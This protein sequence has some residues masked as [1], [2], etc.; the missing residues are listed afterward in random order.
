[1]QQGSA[2]INGLNLV[3]FQ[4][5]DLEDIPR[6]EGF[7]VLWLKFVAQYFKYLRPREV[8]WMP[9]VPCCQHAVASVL[10]AETLE[11]SGMPPRA[12]LPL[13]VGYLW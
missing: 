1:M 10:V 2:V 7:R 11:G 9:H 6:L 3:S 4:T 5:P 13:L 12:Y 8:S